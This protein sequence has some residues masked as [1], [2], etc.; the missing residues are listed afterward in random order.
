[1]AAYFVDSSG[2]AKRYAEETGSDW[3]DSILDSPSGNFIYVV[4]LTEVEVSSAIARRLREASIEQA[5]AA[6][7]FD[8]IFEDFADY[9][10]V[11]HVTGEL[12][13]RAIALVKNYTLRAYDA[14][15]L[16]AALEVNE[17]FLAAKQS[18]TLI[19]ADGALNNAAR[20]E[21]LLVEDPNLHP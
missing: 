16:A 20:A 14:I 17:R 2:L 7:A 1:M 10:R 8:M 15:Q 3:V 13:E 6:E 11:A 5:D 12:I 9:F 4:S 19:S 18:L 21:G